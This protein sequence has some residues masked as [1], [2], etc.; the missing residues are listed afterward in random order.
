MLA[1][2][3]KTRR[4]CKLAISL[5]R[6]EVVKTGGKPGPRSPQRWA[7]TVLVSDPWCSWTPTSTLGLERRAQPIH[8]TRGASGLVGVGAV[9]DVS[10]RF[11]QQVG[12]VEA[13]VAVLNVTQA[14][15][16]APR[17]VPRVLEQAV[18]SQR[19]LPCC[20]QVADAEQDLARA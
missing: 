9:E 17:Q 14:L 4:F 8:S 15:A 2:T 7:G 19:S 6:E 13:A 18:A 20:T 1:A 12:A 10:K 11:L 3:G 16:L 5:I